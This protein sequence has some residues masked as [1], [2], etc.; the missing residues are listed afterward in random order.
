MSYCQARIG[1]RLTQIWQ[2]HFS[3]EHRVTLK[4]ID[5]YLHFSYTRLTA[6]F[7]FLVFL[8]NAG[9]AFSQ[10]KA[11]ADVHDRIRDTA[12]NH[13]Q[14]M[15]TVE[16]LSD[17][18]G[19]R[20]TGS[21][22]LKRAEE[23]AR[24]KLREWGL[25][26]AHLEAW[27]PFGRGWSLER[28]TASLISPRF[29]PLIAYPKAWSPNTNGTVRADAVFLN[30]KSV[31]DLEKYRGK[32][33]GKIVLF[34]NE[35]HV[36]PLFEP[37]AHR[38]TDDELLQLAK[39]ASPGEPLP[40]QLTPEERSIQ[41]LNF[42]KWQFVQSE[43]AAVVLEPSYRDGGTVYVTAATVP[44]SPDVPLDKRAHAWD[45]SKPAVTPQV[46]VSAEQYNEIVR[47]AMRGMDVQ[48]EVNLAARF[49]DDD[50][51]SY[52]VVGEIP[53]TDLRDEVVMVGASIDSWHSATGATDNAAGAATALEIIR[54]LQTLGVKPRR[55]IRIGLWSA[56]EQGSLGSR[57]YVAA[58]LGRKESAAEGQGGRARY[59]LKPE[60]E[61]FDAYLNFDYGTGRI[62]GL[63]LQGNDAARP[64]FRAALARYADLGAST[65]SL[66][67]IG[68]TDHVPFDELRLPAFQWIRD[69]M[70]GENTRAP[71]TNMDTLDHVLEDDIKQ[72]SGV[73]AGVV[74][75]LAMGDEKVPRKSLPS[76]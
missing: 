26:N 22:N 52:N 31:A 1:Q 53:G 10:K 37:P 54:I 65:L 64:I 34:A 35:Q 13:S 56:E 41:E 30:V 74:Y 55:T 46:E 72:A 50:P 57:A 49:F 47:M 69:Y 48:L 11:G 38:R 3:K 32:L 76:Q 36:D 70:E 6:A 42:R 61:K 39:A 63:Y 40:F 51:M 75:D 19:P 17:V 58:H 33:K 27:G 59:E 16:Y 8:C 29:V 62:R 2:V 28:F 7:L 71:H 18:C 60:Y 67:G 4:L 66:A 44:S 45:L 73:G 5:A 15:E 23:Y 20:L 25:P 24:D 12:L 43:G 68:F 9:Q 21:L 14:I